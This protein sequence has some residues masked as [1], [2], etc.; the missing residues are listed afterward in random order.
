MLSMAKHGAERA[1]LA[2]RIVRSI[3]MILIH[4]PYKNG[5]DET[6]DHLGN[7]VGQHILP[8]EQASGSQSDGDGRVEVSTRGVGHE[9]TRHDGE[10]PSERDDNPATTLAFTL[11]QSH[12][13]ADTIAE[14]DQDQRT[15]EF[16][17]AVVKQ[18]RIHNFV[19]L[20]S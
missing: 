9:D 5:T 17:G 14:E 3:E 2:V 13:S 4:D 16:E 12:T 10:T 11:I 20:C 8:R 18:C 15:Q 6:A 1:E 7:R 19:F